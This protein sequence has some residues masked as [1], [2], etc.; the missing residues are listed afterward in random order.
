M[1]KFLKISKMLVLSFLKVNGQI[2]KISI[3][4]V[5]VYEEMMFDFFTFKI[6]VC[7][8]TKILKGTNQ[9]EGE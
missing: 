4:H 9:Y 5:V 8:C 3:L 1:E 7:I 6:T 2:N